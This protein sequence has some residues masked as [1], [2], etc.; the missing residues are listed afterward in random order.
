MNDWKETAERYI[1]FVD[2]MGFSNYVYRNRHDV[3]K[4]RLTLLQSILDNTQSR[5]NDKK[6]KSSY[7]I[8]TVIFSDSILIITKDNTKDSFFS[9]IY[10]CQFLLCD[11]FENRIPIKG[12]LSYGTITAD[13]EKSLFFG[14]A[15]I[16]A[17]TLQE[18]LYVY[19]VVLDEKVEKRIQQRSYFINRFYCIT[20]QTPMK[21]GLITHHTINWTSA[22]KN[23]V[24]EKELIYKNA[25]EIMKKFYFDMSGHPRKYIDNTIDYLQKYETFIKNEPRY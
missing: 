14:K 17:Y 1:A 2:I 11:S 5:I 22:F 10:A 3:V 20:Y 19:G 9:I 4:K 18:Q 12:A 25:V 13:F 24:D 15:L 23:Y 7:L 21:S 8:K 16:D 6:Y